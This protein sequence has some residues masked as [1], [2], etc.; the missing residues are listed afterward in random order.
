MPWKA[1]NEG[2]T[3]YV[4]ATFCNT[5]VIISWHHLHVWW[6]WHWGVGGGLAKMGLGKTFA[7]DCLLHV[8]K[9]DLLWPGSCFPTLCGT[10]ELWACKGRAGL[11]QMTSIYYL[12]PI[13]VFSTP[14][15][16]KSAK[17]GNSKFGF[18]HPVPRCNTWVH[19][20]FT[21]IDSVIFQH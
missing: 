18:Y 19:I 15:N 20:I 21:V 9:I 16:F 10:L 4:A 8:Q 17:Q 13:R 5:I 3:I 7:K 14:D 1:L 6:A 2:P 11:S 12:L